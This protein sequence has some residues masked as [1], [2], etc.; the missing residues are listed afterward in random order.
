MMQHSQ[1]QHG[2]IMNQPAYTTP[3]HINSQML[4]QSLS[5]QAHMQAPS[6]MNHNEF[7][8][9]TGHLTTRPDS[10]PHS[11][12]IASNQMAAQGTAM[13]QTSGN[14]QTNKMNVPE[15]TMTNMAAA[16]GGG[17]IG[18]T[19]M[20][21]PS[22]PEY[23]ARML[24]KQQQSMMTNMRHAAIRPGKFLF[25]FVFYNITILFVSVGSEDKYKNPNLIRKQRKKN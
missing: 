25:I 12:Q 13:M 10:M 18:M 2:S 11:Q 6:Q 21:R 7:S 1:A 24:A 4:N 9:M 14:M 16:M 8:Q 23:R 19:Q 22:S 15:N 17:T 3:S 20:S 5:S